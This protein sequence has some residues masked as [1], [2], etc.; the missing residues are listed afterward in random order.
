M[1]QFNK[2]CLLGLLCFFLCG[3]VMGQ[4]LLS[5]LEGISFKKTSHIHMK[6]GSEVKGNIKKLDRKKGLIEE[7]K[8]KTEDGK[9]TTLDTE[10][11]S[12]MYLPQSAMDKLGKALS[13]MNDATQWNDNDYNQNLLGD[14]Y[15]LFEQSEVQVKKKKRTL[16]M[17]LLNPHFSN[18]IKI[19]HDPFA[20]ETMA[21]SVGGIKVAGGDDKSY[22]ISI[23][24]GTAYKLQKK[25]YKEEFKKIF[26]DNKDIMAKYG[27]NIRWKDFVE[28]VFE[29]SK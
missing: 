19:Y 9:K 25:N 22:Y 8:I 4:D 20:S 7:V 11:I 2:L 14:G 21:P 26:G 13:F 23:N 10:K 6:D 28:A 17:Q 18:K 1:K 24:G 12:H 16:V 27:E 29:Y 5:P 3:T 15:A